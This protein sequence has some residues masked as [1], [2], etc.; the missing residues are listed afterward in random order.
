M[1]CDKCGRL[2]SDD[3]NVCSFC[4]NVFDESKPHDKIEP[5][6]QIVYEI[7]EDQK[8]TGKVPKYFSYGWLIIAGCVIAA[9]LIILLIAGVL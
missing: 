6:G 1:L 7:A 4:G 5:N 3:V 8:K 9:V 2:S